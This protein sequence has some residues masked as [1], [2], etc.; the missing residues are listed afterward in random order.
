MSQDPEQ[1]FSQSI[2]KALA[3]AVKKQRVFDSV[4]EKLVADAEAW[5]KQVAAIT[6]DVATAAIAQASVVNQINEM[7]RPIQ[8]ALERAYAN[9]DLSWVAEALEAG[10]PPNWREFDS[11]DVDRILAVMD[12]TGWCLVWSPRADVIRVLIAADDADARHEALL[13]VKQQVVVDLVACL[14][15]VTHDDSKDYRR[16]DEQAV[17]AFADGHVEAAQAL[18]ASVISAIINGGFRMPSFGDARA[19]FSGD[20]K[21]ASIRAFREQAV[22]NMV[23]N[24][25][26]RYF[27]DRGDPVPPNFSRHA[28]AHSVAAEQYNEVNSLASLLLS[29][30]FTKEADVLMHDAEARGAA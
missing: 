12:E 8:D 27:A 29:V 15:G 14:D 3:D 21:E 4:A 7:L 22:Y 30:A 20:P 17:R 10:M 2:A 5:R 6:N 28:T 26:Q 18:A 11:G 16:A 23:A 24:S 1:V 25:L 9:L 19:R 13:G